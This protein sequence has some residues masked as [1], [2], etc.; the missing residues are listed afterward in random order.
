MKEED[1]FDSFPGIAN[2]I[3]SD[4][5]CA[6]SYLHSRDTV[7]S[8]IKPGNILVSNS[9][10]K[11]YKHNELEMTFGKEPIVCKLRD[12]GEARSVYKQTNALTDVNPT[13][14]VHRGSLAI[15]APEQIIEELS[16]AL[17][18]IDELKTADVWAVLVAFFTI[19]NPDQ[20]YPFQND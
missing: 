4:V 7:H 13:T 10:Y 17:A 9:H 19:L 3:T 1:I 12:L 6:V 11:S 8:D 16:I 20:S 2:V 18:G 15:M 14:A 5:V